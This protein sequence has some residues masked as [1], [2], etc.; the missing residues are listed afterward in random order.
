M[1]K[2]GL[3]LSGGGA[4]GVAHLGVLKTLE[5]ND[6][7]IDVISGTSS[8]SIV[9]ALYCHGYSPDE[10]FR[11]AQ[12]ANVFRHLRPALNF[13]GLIRIDGFSEILLKYLPHNSFDELRIP[14]SVATTNINDGVTT[15][16]DSGELIKPILASSCIPVIFNPLE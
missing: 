1:T 15:F 4:R 16:F 7:S 8:G 9:G 11:I 5:E 12:D 10:I 14:L 6:I 2:I 3:V 13:T